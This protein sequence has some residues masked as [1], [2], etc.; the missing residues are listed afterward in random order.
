MAPGGGGRLAAVSFVM[1]A[2]GAPL[3]AAWDWAARSLE[4]VGPDPLIRTIS[5]GT[6]VPI[7]TIAEAANQS[8]RT[9]DDLDVPATS[10]EPRET[11]GASDSPAARPLNQGDQPT[12]G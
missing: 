9:K 2:N 10:G 6:P 11:L 7:L 4:F 12:P 8:K 5:N 3:P 1:N